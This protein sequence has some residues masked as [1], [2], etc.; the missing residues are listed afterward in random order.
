MLGV[1]QM[2]NNQR[3]DG[4]N[5]T[6]GLYACGDHFSKSK[7]KINWLTNM[8]KLMGTEGGNILK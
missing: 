6:W 2:C 5:F 1:N 7:I 3:E 8:N 4:S